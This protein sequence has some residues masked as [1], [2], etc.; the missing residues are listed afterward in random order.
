MGYLP[1]EIGNFSQIK[2]L[3]ISWNDGL[4]GPLPKAIGKLKSLELLWLHEN[5]LTG[6]IPQELGDLQSLKELKLQWNNMEGEIPTSLS[7][8]KGF[9]YLLNNLKNL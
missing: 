8:L 2:I 6:I 1:E 7:N 5:K 3:N 9:L 4:T